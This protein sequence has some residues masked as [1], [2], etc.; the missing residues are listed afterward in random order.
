M[1]D[2]SDILHEGLPSMMGFDCELAGVV[3]EGQLEREPAVLWPHPRRSPTAGSLL[4]SKG[5]ARARRLVNGPPPQDSSLSAALCS[6]GPQSHQ[7]SL[8]QLPETT[9]FY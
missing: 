9:Q 1:S 3:K 6:H 5:E 4:G 2:L 7:L 8:Y